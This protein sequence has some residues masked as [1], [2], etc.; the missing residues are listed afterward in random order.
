MNRVVQRFSFARGIDFLNLI[1][2]KL[3]KSVGPFA[4]NGIILSVGSKS[5]L[6]FGE[7]VW[8]IQK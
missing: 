5:N 6:G 4:R 1:S 2:S 8:Q 7:R 3:N